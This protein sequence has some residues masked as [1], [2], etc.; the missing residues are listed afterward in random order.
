[1][2]GKSNSL[3]RGVDR[4]AA[5][6][7]AAEQAAAHSMEDDRRQ[8]ERRRQASARTEEMAVEV[9]APELLG[10]FLAAGRSAKR[11]RVEV[12]ECLRGIAHSKREVPRHQDR[13]SRGHVA[14]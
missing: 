5:D 14:M 12:E 11:K 1:M 3:S 2:R 10:G 4:G 6:A 7:D 8:R 9:D 13:W